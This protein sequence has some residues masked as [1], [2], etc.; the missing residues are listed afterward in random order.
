[1]AFET[2]TMA[3]CFLEIGVFTSIIPE[4]SP[5]VIVEGI[6]GESVILP[7][8]STDKDHKLQNIEVKWRDSNG[9]RVYNIIKGRESVVSQDL[10]Y[11]NRV[12]SFS[13]EYLKGNFSIEL[14]NLTLT[15][16]GDF[17][18]YITHAFE[19]PSVRLNINASTGGKNSSRKDVNPE[20]EP[21]VDN[22]IQTGIVLGMYLC[23]QSK[24]DFR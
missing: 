18:C 1:M 14:T 10:R 13:D 6:L 21:E 24:L 11:R 16:A 4:V 19:H 5:Q 9:E 20:K 7:C 12:K 8:L 17:I 22:N 2:L 23:G 3:M 15:D